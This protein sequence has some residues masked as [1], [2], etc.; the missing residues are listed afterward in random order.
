MAGADFDIAAL[1]RYLEA[2]VSDF[3]GPIDLGFIEGGQSNPTFHVRTPGARYVLRKKPAGVLVP[4]A[5]AGRSRVPRAQGARQHR[6]AG[7]A[8]G[9]PVRGRQRH[10]YALLRD[11]LRRGPHLVGPGVAR[12]HQR[13]ARHDVR[14]SQPGAGR[15][16]PGRSRQDEPRELRPAGQLLRTAGGALDQAV[17]RDRRVPHP[18]DGPPR[19]LARGAS[20]HRCGRRGD[21]AQPR[22][23]P[24]RQRPLPPDRAAARGGARL[25]AVDPRSPRWPISRTR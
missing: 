6:R 20:P 3:H 7:A 14:G 12:P 11:A 8:G 17:P 25:G 9:R 4:S 21:G 24:H 18:H 13:G 19:R 15:H 2:H 23:L 1:E 10:R 22:R 5:H 16:S